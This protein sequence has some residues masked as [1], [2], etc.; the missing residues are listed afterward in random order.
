MV[1][2]RLFSKA[3][4]W[5]NKISPRHNPQVKIDILFITY[6]CRHS[7]GPTAFMIFSI[8]FCASGNIHAI[9]KKHFKIMKRTKLLIVGFYWLIL[10]FWYLNTLILWVFF[11]RIGSSDCMGMDSFRAYTGLLLSV[12]WFHEGRWQVSFVMLNV[13]SCIMIFSIMEWENVNSQD[14][15]YETRMWMESSKI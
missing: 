7:I 1:V 3:T 5:G 12:F 13:I 10:Y 6:C 15:T 14:G 9:N 11:M 4:G 2:Q 8:T